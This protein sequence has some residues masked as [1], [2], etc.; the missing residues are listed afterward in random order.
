[1]FMANPIAPITQRIQILRLCFLTFYRFLCKGMIIRVTVLKM[2]QSKVC[3]V[4]TFL[5]SELA[6]AVRI[7][8]LKLF[9]SK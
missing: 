9:Y 7:Q 5:A 2:G 1:M 6:R 8:N 4:F 3:L